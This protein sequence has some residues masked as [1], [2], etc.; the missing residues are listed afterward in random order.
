MQGT[1]MVLAFCF[2]RWHSVHEVVTLLSFWACIA[3]DEVKRRYRRCKVK[4]QLFLDV[5]SM[6]LVCSSL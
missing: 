1:M 4:V 6:L 2:R 3:I 5:Y